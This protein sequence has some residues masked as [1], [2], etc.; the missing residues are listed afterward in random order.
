MIALKRVERLIKRPPRL[1]H[2]RRS[3]PAAGRRD[4]RRLDRRIDA[5]F[6]TVET[7][8]EHRGEGKVGIGGRIRA[9]ELHALCLGIGRVHRDA[10][11][12]GTITL[13][14]AEIDRCL[15]A[16]H[17]PAVRVHRRRAMAQSAGACLRTPPCRSASFHLI[18]GDHH[19]RRSASCLSRCFDRRHARAVIAK[20]RLGMKVTVMPRFRATP[21]T[22][23]L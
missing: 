2:L 12:R 19:R 11:G 20:E 22:T 13:R 4:S 21:F 10:A 8:H 16:G 15:T 7:R 3:A 14:V 5:T 6:D 23:Y 18:R 17:E 9:A 1:R